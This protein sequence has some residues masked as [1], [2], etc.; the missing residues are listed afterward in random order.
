MFKTVIGK[1]ISEAADWLRK[2]ELVAIPTE[3]VYGL[4][5]NACSE[6]AVRNVFETKQRPAYNPLIVHID[7][8]SKIE[9]YVSSFPD[10]AR[11][12]LMEFSPGPLTVL[13][14]TNGTLPPVVNNGRELIA[15][16]IPNHSL[17]LALLSQL[18]FPLVAPSANLFTTISPTEPK[19]VLKNFDGKIPYILDGGPCEV[20]IESTVVG[21]DDNDRPVIYRQGAITEDEIRSFAGYAELFKKEG[22]HSSPG[23]SALHYSPSTK[24]VLVD[25]ILSVSDINY[26]RT[27]MMSFRSDHP[28]FPPGNKFILSPSGDM[29]EAARNLYRALH[30]LDELN[31]DLIIAERMPDTALG[32]AI[33]DRL[34]RA[35]KK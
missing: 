11:S 27:G 21:F 23:L 29:K 4:A 13:L 6:A 5:A 1:N 31:F 9:Q 22:D 20:G 14:P 7:Q 34:K 35:A 19:H 18:E 28:L 32:T 26:E 25:D 3:T 33:N 30:H 2:D 17:T 16:R 8:V 12:M 15:F 24:L 10:I